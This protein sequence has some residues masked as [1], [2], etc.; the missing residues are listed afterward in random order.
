[1]NNKIQ[2]SENVIT[3]L[4]DTFFFI[5]TTNRNKYIIVSLIDNMMR[6]KSTVQLYILSDDIR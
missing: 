3:D 6:K 2:A 4:N 1:M 5:E